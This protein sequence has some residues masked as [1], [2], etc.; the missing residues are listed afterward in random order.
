M[1]HL[2]QLEGLRDGSLS[3]LSMDGVVGMVTFPSF[4]TI[5]ALLVVWASRATWWFWPAALLNAVV[6]AS[7][8]PVGGHHLA[9]LVG[10]ALVTAVT[11]GVVHAW[12]QRART[13]RTRG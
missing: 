11:I 10:G 1:I 5:L 3:T 4:H 13:G 2:E 7:T 6:I 9:D 12:R 8:L